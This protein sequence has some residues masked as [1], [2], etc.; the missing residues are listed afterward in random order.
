MRYIWQW[1]PRALRWDGT[2]LL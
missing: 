2:S 1:Y